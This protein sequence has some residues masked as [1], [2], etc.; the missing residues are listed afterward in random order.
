MESYK[1]KKITIL[2]LG[3]YEHG[4]GLAAVKFFIDQQAELTISDLQT[5]EDLKEQIQRVKDYAKTKIYQVNIN[6]VM[7][8]H[9][10]EDISNADVLVANPAIPVTSKYIK[11]ALDNNIPVET[12]VSIFF[13][14]CTAPIIG[15]TGT[16]GKSTTTALIHHILKLGEKKVHLGG[17]IATMAA[18]ELLPE[19]DS[20]DLVVLEL[21]NFMLEYLNLQNLSPRVAVLLNVLPDHLERYG[22]SMDDYAKVKEVI[23][24]HQS[25]EDVLICNQQNSYTHQIGER[26][27]AKVIW[28]DG[29]D[30]DTEVNLSLT[31]LHG[32]HNLEN[33]L[34]AVKTAEFFGI[35]KYKIEGQLAS[36]VSLE[37]RLQFIDQKGAVTYIND[38][39]STTPLSTIAAIE[40]LQDRPLVLI[41]GGSDKGLDFSEFIQELDAVKAVVWL[42]GAGTD[43]I[44]SELKEDQSFEQIDASNMMEAVRL[45]A[46]RAEAGY[47]VLLSPACASFGL[48]KN[49]FD[50]G[51]QFNDAVAALPA[52]TYA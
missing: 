3:R 8:E 18:L 24:K 14:Q 16:R 48:F 36:F 6:W 47:I 37:G 50:R 12:E 42:P 15:I 2:G 21:S 41:A 33:V 4:S 38:T 23:T 28:F 7:G 46:S 31:T 43:R 29:T 52:D 10:E 34:A 39:T 30:P 9:R 45:A 26:T 22:G 44:K 20:K 25:K 11:L 40:A 32:S 17:N 27:K 49:E 13:K 5:E 51:K 35:D 1:G 19:I